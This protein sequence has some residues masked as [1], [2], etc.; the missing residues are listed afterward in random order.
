MP[1]LNDFVARLVNVCTRRFAPVFYAFR[2]MVGIGMLMLL[3][4]WIAAVRLWRRG[5]THG[6]SPTS[7]WR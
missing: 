5:D 2:V 1:G 7:S 4:S 6:P 3:V